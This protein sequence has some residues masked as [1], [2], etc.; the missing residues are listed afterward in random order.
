MCHYL[1]RELI[2]E[3]RMVRIPSKKKKW[4]R[5][6]IGN[7]QRL[8]SLSDGEVDV[9]EASATPLDLVVVALRPILVLLW[10]GPFFPNTF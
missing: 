1:N 2:V 5:E 3:P 7:N 4:T 10:S 8:T 6:I 9:M